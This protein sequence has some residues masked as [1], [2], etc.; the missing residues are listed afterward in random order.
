AAI[1]KKYVGD[2]IDLKVTNAAV[3]E[4]LR[5]FAQISGLNVIVQP[6][7]SGVA[8]AEMENVPWDKALEEVLKINKLGFELDGNVMRIAPTTVLREEAQERQELAAAQSLAI[9]L[10]TVMQRLSYAD[11]VS[12]ASLL[13]AGQAGLL[14][15]RGTV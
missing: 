6:G 12:V 1:E 8:T 15:Q 9:P 11:A 4:V 10:K 7:V 13:K 2:P 5:S 3:T 14:S